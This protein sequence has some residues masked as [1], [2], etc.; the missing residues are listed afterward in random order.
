MGS[1]SPGVLG[2]KPSLLRSVDRVTGSGAPRRGGRE[3]VRQ[4]Q[5][6]APWWKESQGPC[7][8]APLPPRTA[9][10]WAGS[11]Q[12]PPNS[13]APAA[14]N[15]LSLLTCCRQLLVLVT[16]S[17]CPL[18]QDRTPSLLPWVN[19]SAPGAWRR[20]GPQHPSWP[21]VGGTSRCA[22]GPALQGLS[23]LPER[24]GPG[25][26]P[27]PHPSPPGSRA[28]GEGQPQHPLKMPPRLSVRSPW[29]PGPPWPCPCRCGGSLAPPGHQA[30]PT[31]GPWSLL[32]PG[33]GQSPRLSPGT[34]PCPHPRAP[35]PGDPAA[36][37]WTSLP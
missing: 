32:P 4:R 12:A 24:P 22:Q 1:G 20:R 26:P 30:S 5:G 29:S 14:P 34:W 36:T 9:V 23:G 3:C 6:G 35:H 37:P 21:P 7:V 2:G 27:R 18:C 28:H 19:S 13:H 8:P 17:P 15:C 33:Q 11:A 31:P 10:P 16:L 25:R